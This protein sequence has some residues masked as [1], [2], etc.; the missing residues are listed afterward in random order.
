[1]TNNVVNG[2]YNSLYTAT[3]SGATSVYVSMVDLRAPSG[4]SIGT[5]LLATYYYSRSISEPLAPVFFGASTSGNII[6]QYEKVAAVLLLDILM[7]FP[8]QQL[9]VCTHPGLQVCSSQL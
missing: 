8:T 1:V 4:T 2:R 5:G 6:N 9:E 3:K 7:E